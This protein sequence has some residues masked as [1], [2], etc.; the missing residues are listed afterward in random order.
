MLLS[1]CE[2]V[3][4]FIDNLIIS[5]KKKGSSICALMILGF[6]EMSYNLFIYLKFT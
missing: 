6:S 5:R 2:H 4:N 3:F 1:F